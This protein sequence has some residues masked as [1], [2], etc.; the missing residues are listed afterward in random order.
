MTTKRKWVLTIAVA[1]AA[2]AA[3]GSGS[4]A[5]YSAQTTNPSN[6]FATGALVLTNTKQGGS[7]CL[8][9]AGGATDNNVN[10]AC[11][12]LFNLTVKKPGDSATV[13][14]T[15][16]NSGSL[17]ATIFKVFSSACADSN[18]ATETFHGTG[19][20]CAKVQLYIQQ[21][22]NSGFS[23]V[24]SCLYGGT[25]VTN[26]CDF[27]DTTKTLTSFSSTYTNSTN[28]LNIGSGLTAGTSSYFTI[29]VMLPSS[30]DNTVQGRAASVDL[31][32]FLQQ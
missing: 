22:S 20:L 16:Q 28:G 27:S 18:A 17:A 12:T 31:S 30:A 7:A 14:L 29:G 26:T 2:L 25:T 9:T 8:S 1:I 6:K 32:W 3:M 21:W 24:S 13:N 10:N 23:T 11:D 5:S 15:V 4:Y 19:S